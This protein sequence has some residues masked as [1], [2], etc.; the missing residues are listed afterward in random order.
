M[1]DLFLEMDRILRPEV[2][3]L[4]PFWPMLHVLESSMHFYQLTYVVQNGRLPMTAL[5]DYVIYCSYITNLTDSTQSF[6]LM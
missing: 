6:A 4:F 3:L 5:S 2:S 1:R